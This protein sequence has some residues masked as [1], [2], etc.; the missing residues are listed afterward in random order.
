MKS[1]TLG[2]RIS[3]AEIT[4]IS[5]H[6]FWILL[7]DEELFVAFREFPWFKDASIEE[8][9]TVEWPHPHHLYWPELDID[10]AVESIRN[11]DKFPLLSKVSRHSRRPS[12]RAKLSPV[13]T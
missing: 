5:K 1:A 13:R 2:K 10:L 3:E 7:A 6:G 11:P 8:I 12:R 4:N 9:V